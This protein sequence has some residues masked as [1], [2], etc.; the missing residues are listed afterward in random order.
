MLSDAW[1]EE[2]HMTIFHGAKVALFA[3]D[4]LVVLLRDDLPGLP[5]AGM[6]DFPGGGREG[7]E[8]P[9]ETAC[10]ETMEEVG[11]DIAGA[12]R[13][14]EGSFPSASRPG[15]V[16]WFFVVRLPAEAADRARLGDEGQRVATMS[17]AAFLAHPR[18]IGFLKDRLR[19][20]G[21][22]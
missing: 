8:T 17:V 6:W 18:A 21:H 10:R 19:A 4:R 5:W 1:S 12:K 20:S 2:H 7:D 13:L 14:W 22:S 15:S 3:G 11:L 16:S 9:W